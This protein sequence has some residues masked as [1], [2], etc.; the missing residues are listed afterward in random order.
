MPVEEPKAG[1]LSRW[2][3]R[4]LAV[5]EDSE[6]S[7]PK[8]D[9]AE[10]LSRKE[11]EL[12]TNR[13]AAEAIDLETLDGGSDFTVF[14]KEGVPD[15]LKRK[16]LATLWLSDPVLANIDG[17]VDYDDD[18]G[19]PD[20]NMKIFKSAYQAGRGY[21]EHIDRQ[22]AA[23]AAADESSEGDGEHQ[24]T[25]AVE[26]EPEAELV[27]SDDNA[28]EAETASVALE[29]SIEF[30]EHTDESGGAPDTE[31]E[32]VRVSLRQ[33]LQLGELD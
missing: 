25:K 21:L 15:V 23:V 1:R 18:F 6:S 16:A 29:D 28:D 4:K 27:G 19:S 20:L 13:E 14:L 31:P 11:A 22:A 5:K 9:G 2:S 32:P 17:L 24:L 33:R 7:D 10:T 12:V 26:D 8:L 30:G 3:Q